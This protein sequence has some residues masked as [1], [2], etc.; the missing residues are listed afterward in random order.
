MRYCGNW[1]GAM[2]DLKQIR[3]LIPSICGWLVDQSEAF[4]TDRSKMGPF[5]Q[6]V[7]GVDGAQLRDSNGFQQ[8]I[9]I[10]MLNKNGIRGS[11]FWTKVSRFSL[12][13]K[14]VILLLR[15]EG[16]NFPSSSCFRVW[17]FFY[18]TVPASFSVT[19]ARWDER[20]AH[21]RHP[22]LPNCFCLLARPGIE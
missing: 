11:R 5:M 18:T 22:Q 13:L 14:K 8:G 7:R 15:L 3:S 17:V 10:A 20:G 4:K 2:A 19:D 9:K 12:V 16:A 21:S 1:T 6:I